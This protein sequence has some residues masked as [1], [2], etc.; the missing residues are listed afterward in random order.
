MQDIDEPKQQTKPANKQGPLSCRMA[1]RSS[2]YSSCCIPRLDPSVHV[3]A[4]PS[5]AKVTR[6]RKTL[7]VESDQRPRKGG[8]I[9]ILVQPIRFDLTYATSRPLP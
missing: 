3:L 4:L 5:Q 7:K 1:F 8:G 2:G 9:N 6:K